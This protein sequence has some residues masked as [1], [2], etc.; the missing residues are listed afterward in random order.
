MRNAG[1]IIRVSTV[2]ELEATIADLSYL[3]V[4]N[5]EKSPCGSTTCSSMVKFDSQIP[6]PRDTQQL[7]L[8]V[9]DLTGVTYRYQRPMQFQ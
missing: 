2:G 9:I 3:V 1:F 4:P 7:S 6:K 5:L 8:P